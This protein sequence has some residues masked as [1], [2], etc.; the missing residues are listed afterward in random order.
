MKWRNQNESHTP[1]TEVRKNK[2][3][4]HVQI[5]REHMSRN[6]RKLVFGVSDQVRHKSVCA[7]TEDD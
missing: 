7:A 1:E 3:D 6:V 4:N 5:Q 2:I